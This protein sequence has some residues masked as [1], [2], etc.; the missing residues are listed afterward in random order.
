[1]TLKRV[2]SSNLRT[3]TL[4]R[5]RRNYTV[6]II[7]ELVHHNWILFQDVTDVTVTLSYAIKDLIMNVRPRFFAIINFIACT[8]GNHT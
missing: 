2:S 5:I 3:Q 8:E 7:H 1:M 6:D 4:K